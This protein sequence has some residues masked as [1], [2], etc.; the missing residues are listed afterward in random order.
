[1]SVGKNAQIPQI[2]I[3]IA[4][5]LVIGASVY[6]GGKFIYGIGQTSCQV[7]DVTFKK[8]ISQMVNSHITYGNSDEVS[9]SA[10]CNMVALCFVDADIFTNN[11]ETFI[12]SD[13]QI[14]ISV[15]NSVKNNVFKQYRDHTEPLDMYDE[16][17]I[18]RNQN[19]VSVLKT[20]LCI[21]AISG[22]FTF[23]T[24][25]FGRHIKISAPTSN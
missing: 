3:M 1:M 19:D 12:G 17:I 5:L 4:A 13:N 10:P 15:H 6:L 22:K 9:I 18:L 7:N 25:G 16:R 8:E 11:P 21:P 24:D 23:N 14:N 20:D 2:F